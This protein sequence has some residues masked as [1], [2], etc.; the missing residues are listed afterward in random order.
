MSSAVGVVSRLTEG[1]SL[2]YT[3]GA[4]APLLCRVHYG[5]Q[6]RPTVRD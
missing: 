2:G 3:R 1:E 4:M 6:N 5:K